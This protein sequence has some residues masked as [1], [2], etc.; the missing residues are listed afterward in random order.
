MHILTFTTL[1]PNALQPVFAVFVRAR[2]EAFAG[3][4]GHRWSVVA[5]VPWFPRLPFKVSPRYD[6]YA[7]M[8]ALEED[9][10]YPL[11]HPRY[12]VTPRWGMAR[13]ASWMAAGA[14]KTVR[15]IHARHPVDFIDAHYVYPDGLAAVRLGAELGIPVILSAR[16]TDLNVFPGIPHVRPLIQEAL[17]GCRA[18]ICVSRDL[19][20]KALE[21]G[22]PDSKALVI[23]NGVDTALFNPGDRDEAR[24]AL[25]LDP[26]RPVMLSVGN[27]IEGK[28]FHIVLDAMAG[29]ADKEALLV[30]AG[31]GPMREALEAQARRLGLASRVRFLGAVP[32]RDLPAWFRAADLF[33]LAT[34]REGWP[35]VV[36]EAQACG[37]PA[38]ATQVSGIPDIVSDGSLGILVAE[39]KAE[40]FRAA[41]DQALAFPW[42][43][44]RIARAGMSRT[45]ENVS[46]ELAKVFT[47][48]GRRV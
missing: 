26:R 43:R 28:G 47:P 44:A 37:T 1:F 40:A 18:L 33:V 12:L 31:H 36:T 3:K 7:R 42:D 16:G 24:R 39:R 45:W 41:L 19:K 21:L 29:M 5:P 20:S 48:A 22:I 27:L 15:E 8:P 9:R 32:N 17:Q 11:Y 30:V 38:V 10:G 6:A 23:G 13:Y 14:R 4:H 46:D 25:G 34:A 2:M 35:N